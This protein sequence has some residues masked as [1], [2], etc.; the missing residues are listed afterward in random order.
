MGILREIDEVKVGFFLIYQ[1]FFEKLPQGLLER[2]I[3]QTQY[4]H[5]GER[6]V[7]AF[8]F[9]ITYHGEKQ[10]QGQGLMA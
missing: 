4:L 6:L 10:I 3:G 8:T 5:N 7:E 9:A 1:T 2:Q